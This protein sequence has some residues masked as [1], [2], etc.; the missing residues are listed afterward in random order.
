MGRE[1]HPTAVSVLRPKCSPCPR[2]PQG[3]ISLCQS[4]SGE[5][6]FLSPCSPLTTSLSCLPQ[7]QREKRV[8][9]PGVCIPL[10]PGEPPAEA[11]PPIKLQKRPCRPLRATSKLWGGGLFIL[12][13]MSK[14]CGT[15]SKAL[16][17]ST[18]MTSV[19]S[20]NPSGRGEGFGLMRLFKTFASK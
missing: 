9:V 16:L 17:K 19:P 10:L 1:A 12:G 18:Q 13:L 15:E 5:P 7:A 2:G 14:S 20:P 6:D 11:G 3:M 8:L 4:L